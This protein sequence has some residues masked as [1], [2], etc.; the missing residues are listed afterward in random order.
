MIYHCEDRT[1][2]YWDE[3]EKLPERCPQCGRKLLRANEADMTGDDWTALG[4]TLWD[5]EASDKKRMVDCFRKA[6]Y[7]G[8]AWGVCNL[9]IC[10]EQGNGV[11][12]D[13]VQAFW[14]YQQAVEM[15]SLNAVC[16]LGVCYQY[17]IGTAPD[18]K[19]A[20]ELYRKAA[21]YGSPRGQMLLARAFHDGIGVEAD[22][23]EAVHWVRAAAYQRYGE[24]MCTGW[25]YAM[26]TATAWSKTGSMLCIGSARRQRVA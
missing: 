23:A 5:A 12:A 6:A 18:A 21:E 17:G 24:G 19:Q 14:L 26:N 20:A 2:N 10:M 22:A 3:G 9:G 4:N 13:P 16:C 1:C 15:G 8:S 11:E 7:L 25:A